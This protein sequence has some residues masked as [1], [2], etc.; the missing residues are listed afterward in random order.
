MI[1]LKFSI[2]M[3]GSGFPLLTVGASDVDVCGS[4][5]WVKL[6]NGLLAPIYVPCKTA[7]V[8]SNTSLTG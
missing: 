4:G 8:M 7:F 3:A 1:A 2:L 5:T 6:A